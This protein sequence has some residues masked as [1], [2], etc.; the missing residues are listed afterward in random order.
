MR[1]QDVHAKKILKLQ[2]STIRNLDPGTLCHVAGG[3]TA[4]AC[5]GT[6][7]F[8]FCRPCLLSNEC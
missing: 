8:S 1:K 2:A 6:Q 7:A 4:F 3:V 5:P